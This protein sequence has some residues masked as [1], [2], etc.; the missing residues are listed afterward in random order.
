MTQNWKSWSGNAFEMVAHNHILQIKKALG[1]SG[2]ITESFYW[3]QKDSKENQ[4]AQIDMLFK[5]ADKTVT[6]VEC[7]YYESEFIID[8]SYEKNLRNKIAIFSEQDR[9][10]SAITL[11]M[12]TS[13]GAKN[14]NGVD[15]GYTDLKLESLFED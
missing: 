2:V 9:D 7:K 12:L 11:A 6:I 14:G 3:M 13:Y 10:N 8:K 5:R 1:I 15:I 4:G